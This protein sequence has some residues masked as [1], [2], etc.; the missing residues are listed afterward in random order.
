SDRSSAVTPPGS[1]SR[2]DCR[3]RP[4]GATASPQRSAPPALRP[5]PLRN[6]R[7]CASSR[8]APAARGHGV[9]ALLKHPSTQLTSTI[10]LLGA[11]FTDFTCHGITRRHGV[12][13]SKRE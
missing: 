4:A 8:P 12:A 13:E 2:A 1:A 7:T 3:V 10:D 9:T 5:Q 6:R 11:Y